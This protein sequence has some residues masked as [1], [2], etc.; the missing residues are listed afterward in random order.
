MTHLWQF[1]S[2]C[3]QL[4]SSSDVLVTLSTSHLCR[5]KLLFF[6]EQERVCPMASVFFGR[7]LFIGEI[8]EEVSQKFSSQFLSVSFPSKF[9][10]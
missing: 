7:S 8:P 5:Q 4:H 3:I 10:L 6:R 1:L 9:V 2:Q